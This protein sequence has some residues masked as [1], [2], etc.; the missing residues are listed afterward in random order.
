VHARPIVTVEDGLLDG[1]PHYLGR[2]IRRQ[3]ATRIPDDAGSGRRF[4]VHPDAAL[5]PQLVDRPR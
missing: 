2:L 3:L 5:A 4:T 1:F